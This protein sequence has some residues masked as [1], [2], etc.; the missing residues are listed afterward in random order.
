MQPAITTSSALTPEADATQSTVYPSTDPGESVVVFRGKNNQVTRRVKL[1]SQNTTITSTMAPDDS[2][3][4]TYLQILHT[5][6]A[7]GTILLIINVVI[8]TATLYQ[9][10]SRRR[11]SNIDY[12]GR[13]KRNSTELKDSN[14]K[15]YNEYTVDEVSPGK[16]PYMKKA[17]M[18]GSI[19]NERFDDETMASYEKTLQNGGIVTLDRSLKRPRDRGAEEQHKMCNIRPPSS[20]SKD[21]H[22]TDTKKLQEI[23]V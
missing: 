17:K 22:N 20:N 21:V 18:C 9:K 7:V 3:N 1:F 14:L 23:N 10:R 12:D 6:I 15:K 4:S 11:Y 13:V 16:H 5:T 8:F 2:N 19:A